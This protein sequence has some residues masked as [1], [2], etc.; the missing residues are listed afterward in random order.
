VSEIDAL[1][2]NLQNESRSVRQ[3]A[4]AE[5]A[6]FAKENPADLL[7]VVDDVL[8]ALMRPEA[9]T[10]W[11]CLDILTSLVALEAQ[12]CASAIPDAEFALFDEESGPLRCS[13]FRFL[14]TIGATSQECSARVWP[15]VDQAIQCYHGDLEFEDMMAAL[16]AFAHGSLDDSVKAAFKER[17]AFD[18]ENPRGVVG[19]RAQAIL[20]TLA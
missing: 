19:R 17:M 18:A 8:D 13:A 14:C 6:E 15:V 10:R 1:A 4:A 5:L 16:V 2:A 9:R 3:R 7:P 11:E 12:H 20:V